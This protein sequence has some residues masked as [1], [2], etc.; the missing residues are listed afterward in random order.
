MVDRAKRDAARDILRNFI[1]CKI[2]N[3]E[4]HAQ[5]LGSEHDLALRAIRS[6]V[7]MLYSD[8]HRHKLTGRHEPNAKTRAML[9]RCVLFLDSDLEFEW[10]V[11][12]IGLSNVVP[13]LRRRAKQLMGL[14]ADADGVEARSNGGDDTVWPFFRRDDYNGRAHLVVDK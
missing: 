1:D 13:N 4:F 6:T 10:P 8:L 7:W 9:E 14:S 2:T 5:F 3:D 12:T 11:P